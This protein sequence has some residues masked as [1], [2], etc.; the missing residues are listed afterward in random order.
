M[1]LIRGNI[2]RDGTTNN[3][4]YHG[5]DDLI[6]SNVSASIKRVILV[7]PLS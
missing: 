2:N 5:G 1:K 3:A 7:V 4:V 6:G